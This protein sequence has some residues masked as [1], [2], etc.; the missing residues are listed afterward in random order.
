MLLVKTRNIVEKQAVQCVDRG[1]EK[2]GSDGVSNENLSVKPDEDKSVVIRGAPQLDVQ[3]IELGQQPKS[4]ALVQ[5]THE[6]F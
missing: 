3:K 2:I 6:A 5:E 1:R 4:Q